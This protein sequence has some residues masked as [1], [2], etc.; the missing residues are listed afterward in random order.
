M[1]LSQNVQVNIRRLAVGGAGVGEVVAQSDG[2]DSLLGIT[3]FV[4]F[5]ARGE[6][7][8][9][10]VTEKKERYLK[11]ELLEIESSSDARVSPPCQYYQTCGGCELQHISYESELQAKD[12]MIHGA[13]RAAQ[14]G[15]D[16]LS[17]IEPIIRG[18]EFGYR[19]RVSLHIDN[20]GRI[21]FYRENSRAVVQIDSCM[22]A[23]P[24][25][26]EALASVKILGPILQ[27][28]ATSLLLEVDAKGLIVVIKSPYDL[29]APERKSILEAAKKHFENVSLLV[30]GEEVGGFGRQILEMP[31]NKAGTLSLQ[32]PAGSFSQVNWNM[33]LNLIAQVLEDAATLPGA[34]VYD[35]Y[36]GAGNFSLP[37][38]R[39]GMKVTAVESDSRLVNLGRQNAKR[40]QCDTRLEYQDAKVED[41]LA[42]R[43]KR[44]EIGLVVADPPRSGLGK[45]VPALQFSERLHL[46][47]CHLPSFVRDVKAFLQ[48]GWRVEKIQAFDMFAQTS[49]VELLGIL[50]NKPQ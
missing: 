14:L 43:R 30:G 35:L 6:R 46:V 10:R 47:S 45:L 4:P 3:A 49:H 23:V 12:E 16:V 28:K 34:R 39:A 9:A 36:A 37:L 26:N 17:K 33:N 40:Y 7:V 21:G 38:A 15:S 50:S 22:I 13:L 1:A 8:L 19:R 44:G 29:A 27:Q 2:G 18:E 48:L 5:T 42:T 25:I 32:I 41:F 24:E 20:A 11:A 31:L